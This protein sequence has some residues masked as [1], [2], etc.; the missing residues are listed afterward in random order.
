MVDCCQSQDIAFLQ[1]S[2]I[3][4]YFMI[5][6]NCSHTGGM[7]ENRLRTSLVEYWPRFQY[8][9]GVAQSPRGH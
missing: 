6:F 5:F 4:H 7:K 8:K 2:K 3:L 1:H 9:N